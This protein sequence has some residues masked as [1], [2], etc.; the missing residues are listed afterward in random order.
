MTSL[1]R[2][3]SVEDGLETRSPATPSS[4]RAGSVAGNAALVLAGQTGGN[5]GY[6]AAVVIL[7]R[8][9]GPAAR[10]SVAFVT[11]TAMITARVINVGL[12]E[13]AQVRAAHRPHERAAVLTTTLAAVA[14]SSICGGAIVSGA[15]ALVPGLGP[16][17]VR[18][19]QLVILA[20]ATVATAA[21]S[22][23]LLFMI[24][25]SRF[26]AFAAMRLC[27]PWSYAML[28][29]AAWWTSG[30]T[31]TRATAL[32]VLAEAVP[33]TVLLALA[34]RE[35]GLAP[36]SRRILRELLGFGVGAWVG[37]LFLFLN[38][39][40]DQVITGLIASATTLGI[41]AVA[42]NG[43]EVLFYL[44]GS[45]ATALLPSVARSG[46]SDGV[47]P[48]LRA[49]RAVAIVTGCFIVAAAVLGPIL[50]P[51]AFG[52][53]YSGAVGPFLWLL[54]SSLGYAAMTVF[55]YAL[56][57]SQSPRMSSIGPAVALITE[58]T[59]DVV[60]IPVYGASGAAV[61]ATGAL[62]AGGT[63]AAF[64]YHFRVGFAYRDLMPRLADL[65]TF[66]GL[67]RRLR[68][69]LAATVS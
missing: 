37:S 54:P 2:Q 51:V 22:T 62:L 5:I 28:L 31:S 57:A 15:L 29:A 59:L 14:A 64:A 61:A 39:R 18:G 3:R 17:A 1:P 55:S 45:V 21:G 25:C 7:A 46:V 34:I 63:A 58:V 20:L 52:T 66:S 23:G 65:S 36:P 11:V 30:L 26:R 16:A 13:A 6:L 69:W 42:V 9:L 68:R 44:P 32:W 35:T 19:P 56:V 49:F 40:V 53:P 24:G 48:T 60:L 4:A 47:T 41:Y 67:A 12:N 27:G 10:G 50:I 43:S 38:A 33:A 8:A